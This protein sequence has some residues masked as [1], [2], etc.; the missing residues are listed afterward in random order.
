VLSRPAKRGRVQVH[1]RA[2]IRRLALYLWTHRTLPRVEI[3]TEGVA[4]LDVQRAQHRIA[5]L[6]ENCHC[7]LGALLGGLAIL[8][9]SFV[10]Q[11]VAATRLDWMVADSWGSLRVVP[12]AA[13]CA[14]LAGVAIEM[15]WTRVRLMQAV[16]GVRHR[17]VPA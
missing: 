6:S 9:G 2:D 12:V 7:L 8:G 1:T 5:R 10:V 14:A 3:C 4:P 13:L 17:L 15:T 11:W 16:S